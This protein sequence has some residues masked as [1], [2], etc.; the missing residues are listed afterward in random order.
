MGLCSYVMLLRRYSLCGY[1]TVL[2]S[3]ND[4]F[5]LFFIIKRMYYKEIYYLNPYVRQCI[6]LDCVDL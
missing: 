5:E 1:V 3:Y 2:N 6:V 4:F